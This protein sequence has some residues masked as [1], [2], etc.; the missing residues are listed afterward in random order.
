M[1]RGVG[2]LER[3]AVRRG[4]RDR[5]GADDGR[6]ADAVLDHHLL[7]EPL[8]HLDGDDARDGVGAGAGG[9]RHDHLDRPVGPFGAGRA[10]PEMLA[11]AKRRQDRSARHRDHA[12]RLPHAICSASRRLSNSA[13]RSRNLRAS[14]GIFGLPAQLVVVA[15]AHRRVALL[16]QPL[17]ADGLRLGVL[18]R[19]V[20]PLPFVAVELVVIRLAVQDAGQLVGEVEGVVH[21]AV[22]PHAADRAVDVGGVAGEHRAAGAEFF[23][24]ALMHRVEVAAAD[25]EIVVD[26]E[27]ALEPRLQRLRPLQLVLVVVDRG[28][29]MNAPAVRRALPV[30]QVGIFVRIGNVVALGVAV[31]AEVVGDLDVD[32][33]LRIGEALELDVEHP[34]ARCCAR[35]RR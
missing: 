22:Q 2:E 20:P 34:S 15:L 5:V 18:D 27:E 8:A 32:G 13:V 33:A 4:L 7:A 28:R 9:K 25:L 6:A 35:P 16:Q 14:A 21:A 3:V 29:E 26:A 23:R 12:R 31:L 10:A 1:R 24:H 11:A 30:E 19:H 17:V